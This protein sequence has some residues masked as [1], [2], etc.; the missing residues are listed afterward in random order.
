M[1][2]QNTT[3]QY[4]TVQFL[5]PQTST[6]VCAPSRGDQYEKQRNVSQDSCK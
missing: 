1:V 5:F 6:T 3:T 4:T 2:K